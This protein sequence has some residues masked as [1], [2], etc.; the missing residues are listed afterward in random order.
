[1]HIT[2]DI[3]FLIISHL[4]IEIQRLMNLVNKVTRFMICSMAVITSGGH[5][6]M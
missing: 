2:L 1:M 3:Y 4:E 6:D 5:L